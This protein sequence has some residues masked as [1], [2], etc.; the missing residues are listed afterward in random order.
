MYYLKNVPL[1]LTS[2]LFILLTTGMQPVENSLI[3]K[4][5]PPRWRNTSFGIKFILTFG[6]SSF[7]IYPIGF[8]QVHYSLAAV[9]LL[10]SLFIGALII[11]NSFLIFVTR[12]MHLKN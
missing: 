6:V 10:F 2:S 9:F 5:T 7:I 3:A 1:L 4:F 8:F 11:N 12:G